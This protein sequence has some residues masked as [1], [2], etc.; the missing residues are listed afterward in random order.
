M[1]AHDRLRVP[2]D[3]QRL[4]QICQAYSI[5]RLS[6]FGSALREDFSPTSDIDLLVVFEPEAAL[7]FRLLEL[8]S[9]LS[10]LFGGRKV[11]LVREAYLNRHVRP[12][13]LSSSET[14]YAA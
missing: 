10:D 7:G 2:F 9:E 5:R 3:A 8:E 6:V 11:D 1:A 13:V 12:Y 14:L 4:A